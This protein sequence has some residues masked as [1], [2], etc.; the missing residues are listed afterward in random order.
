[1]MRLAYISADPGVPVFGCKG[2]SVHVQEML[3]ALGRT[4]L[5][6]E[7]FAA[8]PGGKPL[9]GL[10]AIRFHCLP[11]SPKGDLALREQQCMAANEPLQT[12]LETEG[13]FDLVY[14]RYSL[15][16]YAAMEYARARCIPALL[17]V[18]APLIEE[19][20]QY[21]GLVDRAGAF[22][23]ARRVFA[24]AT[25]LLA[26]YDEVAGYLGQ[27]DEAR[28]KVHV[29]PNGVNLDRFPPGLAPSLPAP[30][31][32]V[33]IG[34]VGSMKP[35]HGL[36]DLLEAFARLQ[37]LCPKSR[38]LLVGDGPVRGQL[39]AQAAALG[40]GAA[41]HF[42]GAVKPLEVPGLLRS[43]DMA[44]APYPKM[45]N[46]YF[47]PLKVF[48]YMAAGLPVVASAVGQLKQ[49]IEPEVT[50]LLVPPSDP[51]ALS[52]ALARLIREPELRARVGEEARAKVLRQ[53]TWDAN[54][55]RIL[56][57]ARVS[58]RAHVQ[59]AQL[60]YVAS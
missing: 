48:E 33:T 49:L 10:E 44:V 35:W 38:L 58:T 6:I 18:N 57:I 29:L 11:P 15:W 55:K 9:T 40:L 45:S 39:E 42:T 2:C 20:A 25:A 34:F 30:P 27:F 32:T 46:F 53:H 14:E 17:E 56:D 1:M 43:M 7:L 28:G 19:Q 52:Q 59:T 8:N 54:A 41:V 24:A 50:G 16:S 3:R 23:V 47:S 12:M 60:K 36:E 4:D 31:G 21:R 37:E 51:V 22:T 5:L 26:V 13:P